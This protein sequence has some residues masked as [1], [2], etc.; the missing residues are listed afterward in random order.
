[1]AVLVLP[2]LDRLP[3]RATAGLDQRPG[4][5]LGIGQRITTQ[6]HYARIASIRRVAGHPDLP[7]AEEGGQALRSIL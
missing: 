2:D 1:V 7:D 6:H 3:Q 5:R 4:D